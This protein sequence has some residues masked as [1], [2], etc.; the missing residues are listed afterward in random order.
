MNKIIFTCGD[1]NGI[2]PE[3]VIK[4][5]QKLHDKRV[6]DQIIFITPLNVFINYYHQTYSGFPFQ[7]IDKFEIINSSERII[8]L[9][10]PEVKINPGTPDKHS[11]RTAFLSLNKSFE[12]LKNNIADAVVTA[13]V[14]KYALSLAGINFPGQTEMFVEWSGQKYYMM[15]FLSSK[16]NAG[17]MTIHTQ[18][19]KVSSLITSKSLI[20]TLKL[21][22]Q[23]CINDLGIK[24]PK[25]AV[26][27]LNPHAGENGLIGNEE[28]KIF[29]PV[30]ESESFSN[31][32]DGPY[33]A[34]AF[35][36][37]KKYKNYDFVLGMYHDQV[38]IPF[39]IMNFNSG[40]NYTAG[41]PI[42]RTSPDH[43]CAF[44]IAGSNLADESSIYTAYLYAKKII[45]NRK[46]SKYN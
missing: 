2:G 41:L 36:A 34:D 18:L 32:V 15:T 22:K 33:P 38:L 9:K 14:S 43:G 42:I 46:K 17:L 3:I 25:V 5:L 30:L 10:L 24:E 16:M 12:I 23:T 1:I 27:G 20:T 40:V 37:M 13:P 35:F 45:Q 39:K 6:K 21:I 11:G 8:I 7:V 26:L 31:Y 4:T 19:K 44:D 28:L 29:K